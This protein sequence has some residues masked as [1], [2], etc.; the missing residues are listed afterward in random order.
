MGLQGLIISD[1]FTIQFLF[2]SQTFYML[3]QLLAFVLQL[4]SILCLNIIYVL[5]N[6]DDLILNKR[7]LI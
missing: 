3:N 6:N 4:V 5:M 7:K 2:F 1:L